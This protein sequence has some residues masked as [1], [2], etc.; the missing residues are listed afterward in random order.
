MPSEAGTE[1]R[2]SEIRQHYRPFLDGL[3]TVAVKLGAYVAHQADL[4]DRIIPDLNPDLT[5]LATQGLDN[6]EYPYHC[7]VDGKWVLA[8]QPALGVALVGDIIV[9]PN[10]DHITA[11][12]AR[13]LAPQISKLIPR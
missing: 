4:S 7:S 6:P 11:T 9:R 13:S 10:T 12:F 2:S 8:R 3:T 5:I 1:A